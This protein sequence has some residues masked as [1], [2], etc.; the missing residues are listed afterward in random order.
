MYASEGIRYKRYESLPSHLKSF[1]CVPNPPQACTGRWMAKWPARPMR[2]PPPIPAGPA[3]TGHRSPSRTAAYRGC[4]TSIS[5]STA[6]RMVAPYADSQSSGR[7]ATLTLAV[8]HRS[9]TCPS[10]HDRGVGGTKRP[11][12]LR[13]LVESVDDREG[14]ARH[15][16]C[17]RDPADGVRVCRLVRSEHTPQ[18][19]PQAFLEGRDNRGRCAGDVSCEWCVGR[20]RP[21]TCRG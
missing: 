20:L 6:R 18:F 9:R 17:F 10:R 8:C 7:I 2:P 15:G 1:Q 4:V 19:R 11:V 3:R 13:L 21:P 5:V 12:T 16:G 14:I